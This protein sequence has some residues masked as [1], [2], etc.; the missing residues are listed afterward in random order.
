MKVEVQPERC[1]WLKKDEDA[2]AEGKND[3]GPVV[4]WMHREKRAEDNWALLK[5]QSLALAKN[6][7]LAVVMLVP[8]KYMHW[9]LRH[10]SFGLKG[11]AETQKALHAKN[12]PMYVSLSE[13]PAKDLVSTCKDLKARAL[14]M[15]FFPMRPKRNWDAEVTKSVDIPVCLVDA[16]NVVPCWEAS[17][18]REYAA[19]TI[20]PKI[21]RKKDDFFDAFPE[22][23]KMPSSNTDGKLKETDF[24]KMLEELKS[25]H[26]LDTSVKPVNDR[27]PPGPS[28]AKKI[29]DRF[30][31]A[32]RLGKY[33]EC[34]NDPNERV[35]SDMSP[36]M[37]YG[38]I[39]PQ[40]VLMEARAYAKK[41][42][43]IPSKEI[44]GFEE[45][46]LV[47]RE[48]TDNYCHYVPEY[49]SL[50]A[51]YD[52]AR[53]TLKEHAKDKRPHIYS[54]EELA[55]ARTND[56]LWNAAQVMARDEG[57]MHGW[58]RMYWAKQLL[59]WTETPEEA[60][61]YGFR[62]ND[63]YN[64]DGGDPNSIVGVAWS[65]MGIHDQ[66][67][68]EREIF[69][70]IRCM[71]YKSSR[72]KFDVDKLAKKY[73]GPGEAKSGK[74]KASQDK[75]DEDDKDSKDKDSKNKSKKGSSSNKKQ[76][77]G[78]K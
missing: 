12:I 11:L 66:G 23:S 3:G 70:K 37:N 57:K 62:L 9:N 8:T 63:I 44:D 27:F 4:Y 39:A 30:L 1:Q 69:G 29:L 5:A 2:V 45:E 14:V 73:P 48:L 59:T 52:W 16:H 41:N 22:L 49:D 61:D 26:K 68:R 35:L 31:D 67:W 51:A 74:R 6:A 50:D 47:R 21:N 42:G 55:E 46:A 56:E 20:R 24:D 53:E 72:T 40:R 65:I 64:L 34:R 54:F 78:K 32:K 19:R 33:S 36:Y 60:L 17:D 18:K 15:D 43:K 38:F 77:S 71:T 76:K 7:S 58:L 25:D 28:G 13:N 10:Y 75:G